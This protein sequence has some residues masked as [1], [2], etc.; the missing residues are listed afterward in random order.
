MPSFQDLFSLRKPKDIGAGLGSGLKSL[1]KGVL[2]GVVA[3]I[4]APII[5]ASQEGTKG[6]V[7]GA[8]LGVLG[9]IILPV[10]GTC[11][12]VAQVSTLR[13]P[14]DGPWGGGR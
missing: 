10:T 7:K 11:I 5:G 8:C 13:A 4:G 12:A 1:T 2:G 3:L 9:A 6:F 14:A